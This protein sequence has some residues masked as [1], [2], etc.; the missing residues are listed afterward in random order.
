VDLEIRNAAINPF[1]QITN[2]QAAAE[3]NTRD[4]TTWWGLI[5]GGY[6]KFLVHF[7][8]ENSP[9]KNWTF[10]EVEL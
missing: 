2:T 1:P 5:H 8:L 7:F 3:D 9:A 10:F 4:W 6:G